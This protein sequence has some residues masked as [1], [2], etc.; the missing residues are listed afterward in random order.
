MGTA[1]AHKSKYDEALA[2]YR[3]AADLTQSI[4]ARTD[5]AGALQNVAKMLI[6]LKRL[7]EAE[8]AL[9][10]RSALAREVG[11]NKLEEDSYFF[12]ADFAH[13]AGDMA[14]A[15]EYLA[16][17]LK[18]GENAAD[19]DAIARAYSVDAMYKLESGG[20][21]VALASADKCIE[22]RMGIGLRAGAAFCEQ[23]KGDVLLA[24]GRILEARS[25]Y[26]EAEAVYVDLKQPSDVASVWISQSKLSTEAGSPAEGELPARNAA[27]ECAKEK[28]ADSQAL[29][30]SALLEALV[31]QSK[32]MEADQA[33][34]ELEQLHS[35]DPEIRQEVDLAEAR[36]RGMLGTFDA[37]VARAAHS[38]EWCR[39]N[40]RVD[41]ELESRL[42]NDQIRLQ[43]GRSDGLADEF[44]A[45]ATDA[46]RLGFNLIVEKAGKALASPSLRSTLQ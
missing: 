22:I 19:K 6:Y 35:E 5:R 27:L 20:L 38:L 14:K 31:A 30:L 29:A 34:K 21:S 42:V 39:Q 37:A 4:G 32:R 13:T 8:A 1:L 17:A 16:E 43:A 41:C 36:Y 33:W 24:Q 10:E 18:H 40:G 3:L 25:A 7:P 44:R 9:E 46:S 2:K 11:D 26:A 15:Q 45:L 12:N 28:D 23:T